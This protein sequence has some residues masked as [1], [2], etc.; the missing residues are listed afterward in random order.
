MSGQARNRL[1][2]EKSPY[3][4]QHADNPVAWYPWGDEA[5]RQAEKED[6]PVFLSIGYSTCHWCHV[7]ERESFADEEIAR[8]MN[9]HFISIKVDREE[10]PDIDAHCMA[11]CQILTGSGGWPL[12]VMMTPDK[13]PFFAGTYFPRESRFGL[14]GLP[15]LIRRIADAWRDRRPE[16]L[17]SAGRILSALSEPASGPGRAKITPSVL[18]EAYSQLAGRFDGEFGG[19]GTAPK[20]PTPHHL[21]FLLRYARRKK[22]ENA[23]AM[24]EK[25]LQAMRLGGI[26]DQLGFGFHRYSTDRRWL[27]PHFEKMLYDQALLAMAYAETFQYTG[28]VEYR[29]SAEEIFAYVLRDL[30]SPEGAFYTAEDA[31]S[32]GEEGKYYVWGV[33]EIDRSLPRSQAGL[34]RQIFGLH[35]EGNYAEPGGGLSGNNILF[36]KH[37]LEQFAAELAISEDALR[38]ELMMI[39]KE[40]LNRRGKRPRPLK[41]TKILTDWNGLMIAALAGAA[42][43]LGRNDYAKA[44]GAAAVYIRDNMTIQGVLHHRSA[45]GEVTVPAFLDDYAFLI[46]G[47]LELYES[48]FD[49]GFLSWAVELSEET[50]RN[51][52]DERQGGFFFTSAGLHKDLPT[53]RKE[54][55]D[56]ALPSGNSAM[57]SN[58][59]RLSRLL[60]RGDLEDRAQRTVDAFSGK[61]FQHPSAYTQL[62]CGLD[63]AFGPTREVVIAGQRNAPDTRAMFDVLRKEFNPNMVVLFRPI[64][65]N[66][67]EIVR[68]APF[69]E[70]MV[71]VEDRATVYVCSN[72]G[73][74]RPTTDKQELRALLEK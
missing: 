51:F 63:F 33:S 15:D 53:R 36:L 29:R 5:F 74:E 67:P 40:L 16:L 58:L 32:E 19:F 23:L 54:I 62:L 48:T 69:T 6:K 10:R 9:E 38:K 17:N 37:P 20:F 56:G 11:V 22:D 31:D 28:K 24:V 46:W 12:T 47:L 4:R 68:L 3:L 39:R 64:E 60:G 73:C 21:I 72:Y 55:Y 26:F 43:A 13:R 57:V 45:E 30:R 70:S 44:A 8:L 34:A 61:I 52:W 59:L 65:E 41:D 66:R 35:P 50:V 27:V 25:T 42:W 18:D 7:M 1:D 49:E 2:G 14:I 71:A